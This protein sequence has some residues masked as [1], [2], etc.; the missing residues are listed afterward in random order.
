MT[1]KKKLSGFQ[2]RKKTLLKHKNELNVINK[3]RRIQDMF[4]EKTSTVESKYT[5][6]NINYTDVPT[7]KL[8]YTYVPT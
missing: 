8:Q 2:N 3:C 6:N 5:L 7:Y 4:R 1:G